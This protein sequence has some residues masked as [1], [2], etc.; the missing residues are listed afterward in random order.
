M[1]P[2]YPQISYMY[3]RYPTG[4][5]SI[6]YVSWVSTGILQVSVDIQ[7]IL[8]VSYMYLTHIQGILHVSNTYPRYPTCI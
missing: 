2:W 6:V 1:Y 8:Q 5:Q 3:P 4:I 7:G